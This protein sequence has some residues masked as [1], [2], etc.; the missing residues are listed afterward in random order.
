MKNT[1]AEYVLVH[2]LDLEA[3][4]LLLCLSLKRNSKHNIV[5]SVHM[6]IFKRQRF[7]LRCFIP[8]NF[9]ISGVATLMLCLFAL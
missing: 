8:P 3:T 1:T 7:H 6:K 4:S 2:S 9:K 5:F